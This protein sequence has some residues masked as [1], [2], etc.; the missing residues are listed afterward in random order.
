MAAQVLPIRNNI[1]KITGKVEERDS[2]YYVK[3]YS[4]NPSPQLSGQDLQVAST[5]IGRA[6]ESGFPVMLIGNTIGS[7][8]EFIQV[9]APKTAF[10]QL[11]DPLAP[12]ISPSDNTELVDPVSVGYMWDAVRQVWSN[13]NGD[14]VTRQEKPD[15]DQ[16]IPSL[17]SPF[18]VNSVN[19]PVVMSQNPPPN[20][21]VA[22]GSQA[23][24]QPGFLSRD[25]AG[26]PLWAFVLIVALAIYVFLWN[27]REN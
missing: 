16:Y 19:V 14:T 27:K 20:S 21:Q 12:Q 17:S 22:A 13:P 2:F 18:P 15:W 1:Q 23:S 6:F 3:G 11:N 26:L 8:F 9:L 7:R 5:I 24:N 25:I 10:G 4:V